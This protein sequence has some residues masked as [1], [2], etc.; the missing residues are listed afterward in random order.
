MPNDELEAS[1][2]MMINSLSV[3][4]RILSRERFY[5]LSIVCL[6]VSG[7][8][9]SEPLARLDCRVSREERP[10]SGA[11]IKFELTGGKRAATFS[12]ISRDDGSCYIDL[13]ERKGMPPGDYII[14]VTQYETLDGRPMPGGEEGQV[15]R[16]NG[17]IRRQRYELKKT[18]VKGPNSLTLKLEEG[19]PIVE[20]EPRA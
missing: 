1:V 11:E 5:C 13:G 9:S 10:L 6:I 3:T 2:E 4:R 18:F 20:A 8:G 15:L 12:A 19:V 16:T 7:C 17:Q 14:T